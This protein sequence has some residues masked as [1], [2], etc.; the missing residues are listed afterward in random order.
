MELPY[1]GKM[2]HV[3]YVHLRKPQCVTDNYED[4]K[5]FVRANGG[6]TLAYIE[7]DTPIKINGKETTEIIAEANCS[8]KDS[9]N[10]KLGRM[11]AVGRLKKRIMEIEGLW[12]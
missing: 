5:K 9:Y 4:M 6:K 12:K 3:K 7:L 10:K 1:K 8:L 11:I 2:Y